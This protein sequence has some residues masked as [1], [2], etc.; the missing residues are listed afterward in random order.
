MS[1]KQRFDARLELVGKTATRVEIPFDVRAAFGHGRPP[2]RGTVNGFP[3]RSTLAKYGGAYY[4]V[5]NRHVRKGAGA[6]AGD[7]VA[8]ELELDDEPREVDVPDDL[9]SALAGDAQARATFEA[10][11]YTHRREYVDWITEAKREE[12]R[13][14]RVGKAVAMLREGR[15]HR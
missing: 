6:E 7:T 14:R 5:V 9:R 15:T 10:H 13:L 11:S 8:M 4:L 1:A 2:V 12:T 3:F